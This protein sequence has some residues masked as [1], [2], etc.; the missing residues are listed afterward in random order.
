MGALLDLGST[1]IGDSTPGHEVAGVIEQGTK[2][3]DQLKKI[4]ATAS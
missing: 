4:G 3:M 2:L 1:I